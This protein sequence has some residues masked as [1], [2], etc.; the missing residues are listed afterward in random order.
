MANELKPI[1]LVDDSEFDVEL[2]LEAFRENQLAD[3]MFV[4][5]DGE[6]ALEYLY[7]EGRF[8]GRSEGNP[9]LVL[10]D[11]KMPKVTGLELIR[12]VKKDP[13]LIK[14]P[15]V[16]LT[17]SKEEQDLQECYRLGANAYVVKPVNFPEFIIA[18]RKIKDFWITLSQPPPGSVSGDYLRS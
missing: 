14:I 5:R 9:L 8:S 4:L 16:V 18:A 13:V 6:E 7:R 17:T 11:L 10:L 12:R 15:I 3:D 1:L 2:T